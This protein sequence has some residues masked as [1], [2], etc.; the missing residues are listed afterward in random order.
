MDASNAQ[1]LQKTKASHAAPI[2]FSNRRGRPLALSVSRL[3][4]CLAD[5]LVETGYR[6]GV[7]CSG[8]PVDEGRGVS[9]ITADDIRNH[10]GAREIVY[11]VFND[12]CPPS[13]GCST[14]QNSTTAFRER[15][16]LRRDLAIRAIS[17]PQTVH[18]HC[19]ATYHTMATVTLLA[20]P[21]RLASRHKHGY[22]ARSIRG[23]YA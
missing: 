17:P 16:I 4:A 11:W 7:Y 15:H 6:P 21:P 3:F 18:R 13:P 23:R 20:T 12:A 5:A 14:L 9:I 8:M 10:I 22:F 2:I 1:P 19:A